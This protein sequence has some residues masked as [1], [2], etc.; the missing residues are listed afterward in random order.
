MKESV[1]MNGNDQE[2]YGWIVEVM[3]RG[4]RLVALAVLCGKS[5]RQCQ[6]IRA[7]VRRKSFEI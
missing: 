7:N 5:Y 6:R 1:T 3:E 4:L 2:L